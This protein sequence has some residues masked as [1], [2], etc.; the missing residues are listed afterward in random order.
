MTG[1]AV[2]LGA[3]LTVWELGV[4]LLAALL[5]GAVQSA[6]GFG[7]AFTTVPALALLAPQLLPGSVVVAVL[8]LS[9]VMV[10]GARARLD[11][12][13]VGRL[14]LGRLPGIALGAGV[15]AV[16]DVRALTATVGGLL[17]LAV[18][19]SAGG[20]RVRVTGRREVA[21]GLVSGLTGTAAGLGGPPLALLYRDGAGATLRA[22]LA[23]VW[24]VGS[25]PTLGALA[26]AGSLTWPQVWAGVGFGA[27]MVLGLTIAAPLVARMAHRQLQRLLLSWAAVGAV[28]ALLRSLLGA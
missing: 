6:L 20:W 9:M 18:A 26:V 21:A 16:L 2:W 22:T 13:A 28:A 10:A 3:D 11:R 1:T 23:G 25:V 14:T 27:A 15:V 12:R 19:A 17:L 4:V 5:G 24:L 8:P 7:A